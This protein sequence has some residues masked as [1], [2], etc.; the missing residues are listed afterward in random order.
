MTVLHALVPDGFDDPAR[1]SGGN[2]YDR[3]ICDG[4]ASLGWDVRRH[5]V[6]GGWPEPSAAARDRLAE[7]VGSLPAGA[8]LLVD[9]LLAASAPDVLAAHAARLRL[10]VLVHMPL[11]GEGPALAAAAAVITTSS[12]T[13]QQLLASQPLAA[14]AVHVAPPGVDPAEPAAA[15]VDGQR[16]LCVAAVVPHKGHDLL[17]AALG[18]LAD[19]AWQCSCLGPLERDPPFVERLRRVAEAAGIADRLR[20]LGPRTGSELDRAYRDAD[21]LVLASRIESYGMVLAEALARGL[22]V[23]A[24]GVGGVPEALG[25]APGGQLPGLLVPPEDPAALAGA[26][27]RWLAEPRLR[28]RLRAAAAGRRAT[29]AGWPVTVARVDAVLAGVAR[30]DRLTERA[31]QQG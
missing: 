31:A 11:A 15:S 1:P 4:L 29:L 21:V 24:T 28:D 5:R 19:L 7:L 25:R 10:V 8:V 16:L 30:P 6:A 27:R 20:L 23:I 3:R 12:W 14:D 13:R 26:L 22:P 17:V 9:G 2:G 18:E